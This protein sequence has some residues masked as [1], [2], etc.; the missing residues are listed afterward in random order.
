M[1]TLCSFDS[2]GICWICCGAAAILLA[3]IAD[4]A[5]FNANFMLIDF[6]VCTVQRLLEN[7]QFTWNE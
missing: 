1:L 3:T 5:K 7:L 2:E 6:A 4:N